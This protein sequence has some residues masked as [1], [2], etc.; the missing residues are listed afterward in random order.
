M[1]V[2]TDKQHVDLQARADSFTQIVNAVVESGEDITAEDITAETVIQ[3]VQADDAS[4]IIDLQSQ[5]DTA[6]A[7]ITEQ[8]TELQTATARIS[9]LETDLTNQPAE[10]P[11]SITATAEV[12]NDKTDIIDFAK[13]NYQD[14]PFAVIAQAEKEGL[15]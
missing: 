4:E 5:L 14:N 10:P 6:N 1:K 8:E 9:E 15:I 11:A 3:M 2:L 12:T 7:R 13:K